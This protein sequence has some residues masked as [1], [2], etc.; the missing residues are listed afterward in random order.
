VIRIPEHM[1]IIRKDSDEFLKSKMTEPRGEW[2]EVKMPPA[3]NPVCLSKRWN[4]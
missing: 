4:F 3:C 1:A 2:K